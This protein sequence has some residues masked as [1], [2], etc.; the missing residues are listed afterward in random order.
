L[1]TLDGK[2]GVRCVVYIS[3]YEFRKKKNTNRLCV[4]ITPETENFGLADRIRTMRTAYVCAV[5]NNMDFC[6]YHNNG[7][8]LEEYFEPNEVDWRISEEE[9]CLGVNQVKFNFL[10]SKFQKIENCGKEYHFHKALA[11]IDDGFL[12]EELKGRY[13]D[14][15][16]YRKLFRLSPR[17]Q[18]LVEAIMD[19]K[20]LIE[21]EY[22]A[23]HGRFLNFFEQVESYGD[24]KSSLEERQLMLKRLSYTLKKIYE[25]EHKPIVLFS[26][27]NTFLKYP[28]SEYVI[29]LPG[30]VS[31]LSNSKLF[32]NCI[33]KTF[34][35]L[36]VMSKAERIYSLVGQNIYGGGFSRDASFL[37]DK[38]F[39]SFPVVGE[40]RI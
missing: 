5:E 35:D 7:F 14:A 27:S 29:V 1:E 30:F 4:Y 40:E 28:H 37:G 16:V 18:H 13:S 33:D 23:V 8:K 32:S 20:S 34:V 6:I 25:Q 2:L 38:P 17:L 31:H 19:E 21:N 10:Y 36:V 22:I 15:S 12:P 11:N 39:V 9:I 24:V 26:D 3:T